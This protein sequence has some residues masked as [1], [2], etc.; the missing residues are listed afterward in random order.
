[1]IVHY[2]KYIFLIIRLHQ[3]NAGNTAKCRQHTKVFRKIKTGKSQRLFSR[4]PDTNT[5]MNMARKKIFSAA[6]RHIIE[7]VPEPEPTYMQ[8]FIGHMN[9]TL[10][11][12][13][14]VKNGVVI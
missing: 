10:A 7:V 9:S 13:V 6:G 8:F 2:S 3:G 12:P 5:G 1:M 11:V 4:A 14:F